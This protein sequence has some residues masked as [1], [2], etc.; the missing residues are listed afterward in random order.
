MRASLSAVFLA[1]RP[2][3]VISV[4]Q[5]LKTGPVV[6]SWTVIKELAHGFVDPEVSELP[7]ANPS[8]NVTVLIKS[9]FASPLFF[10]QAVLETHALSTIRYSFWLFPGTSMVELACSDGSW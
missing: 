1:V 3:S 8:L 10:G 9:G 7:E 2:E 5:D 6:R 4:T